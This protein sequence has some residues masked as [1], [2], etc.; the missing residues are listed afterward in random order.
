MAA[1]QLVFE[2]GPTSHGE[3]LITWPV[4]PA[5]ILAGGSSSHLSLTRCPTAKFA[6]LMVLEPVNLLI[7]F[8]P[9]V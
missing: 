1:A 4:V 7:L 9:S 8:C 5:G 3:T 6:F 2:N